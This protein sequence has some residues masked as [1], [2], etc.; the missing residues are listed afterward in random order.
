MKPNNT[1]KTVSSKKNEYKNVL[2]TQE[3]AAVVKMFIKQSMMD[4]VRDSGIPLP[5]LIIEQKAEQVATGIVDS[6]QKSLGQAAVF[7][8]ITK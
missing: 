6:V 1:K 4:G 3:Q 7:K 2:L 8:K 5:G